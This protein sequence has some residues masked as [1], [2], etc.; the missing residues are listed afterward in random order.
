MDT[1]K[2]SELTA[3]ILHIPKYLKSGISI[4]NSEILDTACRKTRRRKQRI[5]KC[6][7]FHANA[8]TLLFS[9]NLSRVNPYCHCTITDL[10]LN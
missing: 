7:A 9:C 8:K 5:S 6:Y 4:Y 1:L 10:L 3:S 2:K